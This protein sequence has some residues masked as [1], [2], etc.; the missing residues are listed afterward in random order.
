MSY[1]DF[2]NHFLLCH[3]HKSLTDGENYANSTVGLASVNVE[4][5]TKNAKRILKQN[6]DDG[7]LV[8]EVEGMGC[9]TKYV[10]CG[11]SFAVYVLY[12]SQNR[13]FLLKTC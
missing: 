8:M 13:R 6:Q 2:C 11:E 12:M 7:K 4:Q 1:L 3:F 10:G 9:H 5:N